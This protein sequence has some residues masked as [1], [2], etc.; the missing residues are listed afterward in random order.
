MTL[1]RKTFTGTATPAT[2]PASWAPMGV[3]NR[4]R[5]HSLRFWPPIIVWTCLL[6]VRIRNEGRGSSRSWI[7]FVRLWSGLG[8]W[9][10]RFIGCHV[11]VSKAVIWSA[12]GYML[13]FT[14]C[15][16]LSLWRVQCVC[17]ITAPIDAIWIC[18]LQLGGSV[19]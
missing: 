8:R 14:W 17:H 3:R 18:P 16:F 19:Y 4:V 6:S 1:H 7:R 11:V 9:V 13:W 15:E 12:L 2:R 5:H 10:R